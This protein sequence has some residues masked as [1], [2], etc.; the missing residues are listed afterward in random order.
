M[1]NFLD[2]YEAAYSFC[3][4]EEEEGIKAEISGSKIA[5]IFAKSLKGEELA[6]ELMSV[7][8]QR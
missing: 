6:R 4:K 2:S 7:L 8:V 5:V 1:L 3:S